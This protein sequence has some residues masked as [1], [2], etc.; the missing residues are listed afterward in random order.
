MTNRTQS[1][2]NSKSSTVSMSIA[3]VDILI[4]LPLILLPSQ[5]LLQYNLFFPQGSI[6]RISFE[7]L[8][9]CF[10]PLR[11][12]FSLEFTVILSV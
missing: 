2:E 1:H 3:S 9:S 4:L 11:S 5:S 7:H 8:I 10:F 6:L 12:F